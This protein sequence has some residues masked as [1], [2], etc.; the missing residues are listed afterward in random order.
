MLPV[1]F[2]DHHTSLGRRALRIVDLRH[3]SAER[4]LGP[5]SA[6]AR[7][8]QIPAIP[9]EWNSPLTRGGNIVRPFIIPPQSPNCRNGAGG[10]NDG[11][12]ARRV[13]AVL[14]KVVLGILGLTLA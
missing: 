10:A 14:F 11:C 9:G 2:T 12:V 6:L 13:E 8:K 1:E 4:P 5:D 3:C 7:K